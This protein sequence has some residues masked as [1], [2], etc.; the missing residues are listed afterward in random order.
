MNRYN[1][2][3]TFDGKKARTARAAVQEIVEWIV[4]NPGQ[5]TAMVW[6]DDIAP[7]EIDLSENADSEP[8]PVYKVE[9][10]FDYWG[11]E[12][13]KVGQF[14]EIQPDPGE[15][16]EH[17]FHRITGINRLHVV[18]YEAKENEL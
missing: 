7:I 15:S 16:V 5:V 17:A 2:Q 14:A 11:G 9:Y 8:Q 3:I 10:D 18:H 6:Q 12:Y 13:D 1:V 4:E